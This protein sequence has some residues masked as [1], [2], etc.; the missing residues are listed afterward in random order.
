[1]PINSLHTNFQRLIATISIIISVTGCS[2]LNFG[3]Y[4][5]NGQSKEEFVQYVEKVFRLQNKMTSEIMALSSNEEATQVDKVLLQAEQHMQKMCV[6]LNEYVSRDID[7]LNTSF[8]LRRRVEKSTTDCEKAA[9]AVEF[10]LKKS[11]YSN[12]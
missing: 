9:K 11:S 10:E 12:R 6:D 5:T 2:C 3:K 1:M 7:G 4:G 8:L